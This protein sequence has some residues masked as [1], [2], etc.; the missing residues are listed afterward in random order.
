MYI[1][2][3]NLA[4]GG[5]TIMINKLSKLDNI[6]K[7]KQLVM[8]RMKVD[9]RKQ[10]LLFQG[11][12][13]EDSYSL[14]DYDVKVNDVIQLIVRSD[15]EPLGESQ[16]DNIPKEN[17]SPTKK[18]EKIV[19]EV[20]DGTSD[21]FKVGDKVDC[22]DGDTGA[23][24]EAVIER[25][26]ANDDVAGVDNLTYHIKYEG[27]E[28]DINEWEQSTARNKGNQSNAERQKQSI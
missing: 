21:H 19:K 22:K 14:Y 15:K 4:P 1:K 8:E 12:Q 18:P 16:V 26:T 17:V 11:K 6:E 3:R 13:L 20:T 24:F 9:P 25:I 2:V 27:Y 5:E 23:W 10:R 7:V 28:Q